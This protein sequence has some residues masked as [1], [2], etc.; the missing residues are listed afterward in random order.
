MTP[1]NKLLGSEKIKFKLL[2]TASCLVRKKRANRQRVI[3]PER[4]C[5]E[6][7][8]QTHW[9]D[10]HHGCPSDRKHKSSGPMQ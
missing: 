5:L 6:S 9:G 2:R 1:E 8:R 7:R 10:T 4:N 3:D